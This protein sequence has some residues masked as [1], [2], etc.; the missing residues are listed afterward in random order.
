MN[1]LSSSLCELIT[2]THFLTLMLTA[3]EETSSS[4]E[5]ISGELND[6]SEESTD[7]LKDSAQ[8]VSGDLKDSSQDLKG[9]PSGN[10]AEADGGE[11]AAT[12]GM[13]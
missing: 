12:E 1:A 5:R 13:C 11:A 3:K 6:S 2:G 4:A 8:E 9:E 10:V 7:E